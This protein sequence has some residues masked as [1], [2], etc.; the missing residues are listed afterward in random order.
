MIDTFK[1]KQQTLSISKTVIMRDRCIPKL[2]RLVS[3][4]RLLFPC[5]LLN[6]DNVPYSGQ[7]QLSRS[8]PSHCYFFSDPLYLFFWPF[9]RSY[10]SAI[11]LISFSKMNQTE[12]LRL[13][14]HFLVYFSS[15]FL[16]NSTFSSV[17]FH[18]YFP[19]ATESTQP[20]PQTIRLFPNQHEQGIFTRRPNNTG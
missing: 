3:S 4:R 1:L 20:P 2:C 10:S 5:S 16:E 12:K 13:N 11:F 17:A 15:N 9:Y 7:S 19:S 18:R 14:Q 6:P 8:H